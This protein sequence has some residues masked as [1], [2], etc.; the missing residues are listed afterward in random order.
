MVETSAS[1]PAAILVVDDEPQIHRVMRAALCVQGYAVLE[2]SDGQQAL[3]AFWSEDPDLVQLDVNM[4]IIDGFEVCRRIRCASRVPIIVLTVR[5]S[6]ADKV[7]A[8]EAGADDYVVKRFGIQ[9]I[10]ARIRS[11]LRRS[12]NKGDEAIVSSKDLSIDLDKR[13]VTVRGEQ[14]HLTPKEFELIRELVVNHGRAVSYQR[15]LQSVWGPEHGDDV[16]CLR[17][18][19]AQLRRKIELDPA[20]PKYIHTEHWVGYRFV[21]LADEGDGLKKRRKFPY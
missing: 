12:S 7:Q 13:V 3:A 10:L 20:Q 2:A 1:N 16:E 19:V 9:E 21:L 4:P 18:V 6:E 15:L 5:S 11:I 17:V 14:I 8:L